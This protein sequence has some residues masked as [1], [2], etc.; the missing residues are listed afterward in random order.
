MARPGGLLALVAVV[1]GTLVAGC[2]STA[3]GGT[4]SASSGQT[5]QSK[6]AGAAATGTVGDIRPL[7]GSKPLTVAF[8]KSAGG[9]SWV[10]QTGKEFE[11]EAAKCPNIKKV[12][13]K[14]P[15][16]DQQQAIADINNA[17]AEGVNVVAM[18]ADYGASELPAIRKL[19]QSGATVVMMLGNAGGTV[20]TDFA[21]ATAFDTDW[22]GQQWAA[23]LH[24]QLPNGGKLAYL[25]GVQ[26]AQ[27]SPLFFAGI[28]K[29]LKAY[30][31]LH[32]VGSPGNQIFYDSFDPAKRGQDMTALLAKYGRID[33][34]VSDFDGVDTAV[35][36]AYQAA[37]MKPPVLTSITPNNAMFCQWHTDPYPYEV[38]GSTSS[39]SRLALR[40]GL[41]AH[42]GIKDR[43]PGNLRPTPLMYLPGTAG[44]TCDK[45]L[46]PDADLTADLTKAQLD[47]LFAK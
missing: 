43:E 6:N 35:I 32:F 28:S 23:F 10:T 19:T 25:G 27:N 18:L 8:L 15:I 44:P 45:S 29:A 2:G 39:I 38:M 12:I 46:P 26:G 30:P 41:A 4:S 47:A 42:N 36:P 22:V 21:N 11:L 33:G 5:P 17:A 40:L 37:K 1:V 7:C 16:N 20:G 24:K 3:S 34:V 9:N 13:F 31:N 14:A